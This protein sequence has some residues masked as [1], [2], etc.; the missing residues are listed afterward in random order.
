VSSPRAAGFLTTIVRAC[1][2]RRMQQ[3]IEVLDHGYVRLVEHWGSDERIVEAA[4]M[5][6]G[7]GFLGW[8]PKTQCRY[9][10]G[11]EPNNDCAASGRQCDLG[12]HGPP[13]D[14]RL[15]TY[16]WRNQHATPFEMAGVVLEISLPIFVTREWH[17]HRTQGYSEISSRYTPLPDV[18]YVPSV[19]RLMTSS[20]T[21]KQAGTVKGADELTVERAELYQTRLVEMYRDQEA[22]YQRSLAVGVPKELARVHLPVG[23][24][25]RMRATANLRN[26]LGF[27]TLRM[28]PGAQWEIRQYAGAVHDLLQPLFPRTLGLFDEDTLVREAVAALAASIRAG[29]GDLLAGLRELVAGRSR[30]T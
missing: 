4:R 20:K 19:D 10:G 18:N 14:E 23:R 21:N 7:K 30:A 8:G 17:R 26:W 6:T 22:L 12:P 29:G 28:A 2:R 1:D 11:D 15:L 24:Y 16:L 5:S 27:L 3:Q 9:C 25:T 13:G